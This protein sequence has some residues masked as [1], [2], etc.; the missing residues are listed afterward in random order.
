[1]G[2]QIDARSSEPLA[3]ISINSITDLMLLAALGIDVGTL[4][5]NLQVIMDDEL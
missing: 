1:M 3:Q 4:K 5:Q 2:Q